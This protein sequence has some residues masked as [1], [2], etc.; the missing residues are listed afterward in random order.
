MNNNDN[1]IHNDEYYL[2]QIE[3]QKEYYERLGKMLSAKIKEIKGRRKSAL[4]EQ[5]DAAKREARERRQS[6]RQ[7]GYSGDPTDDDDD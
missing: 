3:E 5:Q 6:R 4:K 7:E 2:K 1:V